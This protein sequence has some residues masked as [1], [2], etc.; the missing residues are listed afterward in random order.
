LPFLLVGCP[1]LFVLHA[2]TPDGWVDLFRLGFWLGQIEI[3]L[4][5]FVNDLL[6]M[7]VGVC[8]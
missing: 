4:A 1:D 8:L 3:L 6:E 2:A 7:E 5:H